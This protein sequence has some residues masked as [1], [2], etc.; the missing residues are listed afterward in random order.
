MIASSSTLA[1]IDD[2]NDY[3]HPQYEMLASYLINLQISI[4][5]VELVAN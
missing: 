3:T 4:M 1:E 2:D 5:C